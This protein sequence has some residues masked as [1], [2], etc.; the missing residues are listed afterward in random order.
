MMCNTAPVLNYFFIKSYLLQ[1]S[2]FFWVK[3]LKTEI[4]IC[5]E[6]DYYLI[7]LQF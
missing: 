6:T 1:I 7:L 2:V 3:R 5:K 4:F